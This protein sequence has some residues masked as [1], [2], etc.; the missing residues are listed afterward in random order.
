MSNT[1]KAKPKKES[2]PQEVRQ[3]TDTERRILAECSRELT[4]AQGA[5]QRA[6]NGWRRALALVTGEE[7]GV[8][9]DLAGARLVRTEEGS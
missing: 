7:P 8:T 2:E 5:M 6:A 3:L 4:E 9:V 1:R